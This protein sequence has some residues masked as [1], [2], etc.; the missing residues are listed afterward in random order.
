[1]TDKVSAEKIEKRILFDGFETTIR[2][3]IGIAGIQRPNELGV[4]LNDN[5]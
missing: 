4:F 2:R 3:R 1:L 5:A